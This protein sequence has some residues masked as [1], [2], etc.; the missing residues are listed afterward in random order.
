MWSVYSFR[1]YRFIIYNFL[2]SECEGQI[3]VSG[4]NCIVVTGC[5]DLYILSQNDYN[6][7]Y[8]SKLPRIFANLKNVS[9]TLLSV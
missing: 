1:I 8:I 2:L 7:I 6:Y 5:N 9:H 4:L 3:F